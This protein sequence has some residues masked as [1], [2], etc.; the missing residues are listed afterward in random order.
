MS[1]ILFRSG[2]WLAAGLL[3]W[4]G[5]YSVLANSAANSASEE[6]NPAH[7][8]LTAGADRVAIGVTE[9]GLLQPTPQSTELQVQPSSAAMPVFR[10][11]VVPGSTISG[12]FDHSQANDIVTIYDGTR[13]TS[14]SFGFIFSCPSVGMY[15]FVGCADP[16]SGE[17]A[18]SNS[19]ELWYDGHKGTDM[20]YSPEWHTGAVCDL[21][22]F[23]GITS[24]V[25]AP[26]AGKVHF[27]GYDPYRPGNGWH[28]RLKHDLN[29][30]GNY[31]DDNFRSIYLHF[32][33]NALAVS[34]GQIV[35]EG[36]YLG[37]GGTT[38][39]SS[40]PHLH[41]EIQK[42]SDYFQTTYWSVDPYGWQ[43]NYGDPWPYDSVR[44]WRVDYKYH[45]QIPMIY[46]DLFQGC[47]DCQAELIR[48]GGFEDGHNSWI[49][50]GV[51]VLAQK[52]HGTLKV[53][54]NSGDW[55]AWLGGRN[56]AADSIYQEFKLPAGQS[57]LT[58]TYH[59]RMDTLET[60]G[61]YDDFKVRLRDS[62]GSL[63][64]E[65]DGVDNSFGSRGQWLE[66]T[67]TTSG[68]DNWDG[69]TLRLSFEG[70]T[71]ASAITSC[72]VDDI[73]LSSNQ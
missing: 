1:K 49:E 19:R 68:L 70:R 43:G 37:L 38:G 36:Q 3:F 10:F 12:Y 40:S 27:A 29:R 28:I 2:I 16:V 14:T 7:S 30:N 53:N 20:E 32:T 47:S 13:N 42:S 59:L 31:D 51:A 63:I 62:N 25:Y 67:V 33:A 71:D 39:Y 41:F 54:P 15:D 72:Y 11:P 24:P 55:L 61:V 21:G 26:A 57:E 58:L 65:I 17:G 66:R 4:G 52:N 50:A 44:L 23:T 56:N 9:T 73:V 18:C 6:P 64:K 45:S 69:Q 34:T 60:E 35:S 5:V 46:Y 48:N 8:S 22:K